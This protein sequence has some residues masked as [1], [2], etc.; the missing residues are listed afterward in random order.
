VCEIVRQVVGVAPPNLVLYILEDF[1]N[2]VFTYVPE[3]IDK[4]FIYPLAQ[5]QPRPRVVLHQSKNLAPRSPPVK[6][7]NQT[8]TCPRLSYC[9]FLATVHF[10]KFQEY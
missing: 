7:F 5:L 4:L 2:V 6:E 9:T 1:S 8:V 3:F 10:E